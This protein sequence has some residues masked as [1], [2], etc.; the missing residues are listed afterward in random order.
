MLLFFSVLSCSKSF[1][2]EKYLKEV[3]EKYDKPLIKFNQI[4]VDCYKQDSLYLKIFNTDQ[5]AR[6]NGLD[7]EPM[8]KQNLHLFISVVE[9]CGFPHDEEFNDYRSYLGIFVVLQH[10][11][12]EWIAHYYEDFKKLI[13]NNKLSKSFLALLEDRLL[14][15]NNRPQ[16][17]GTQI[18]NGKLYEVI[19]PSK[20]KKRREMMD[21]NESIEDYLSR[22]GLNFNEEIKKMSSNKKYF[23]ES[24]YQFLQ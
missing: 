1:D 4:E 5:E 12:P 22:H 20:L 16:L 15:L 18:K 2:K 3:L 8:D 13:E 6:N 7:Y 19:N 23:N 10:N 9:K 21:F 24:K 14:L 11:D 17:Y